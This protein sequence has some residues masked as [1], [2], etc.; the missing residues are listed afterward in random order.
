MSLTL[1]QPAIGST[2]WGGAVNANWQ[3]LLDALN[4]GT[5]TIGPINMENGAGKYLRLPSL[6]TAQRDALT[7]ANGMLI[8]NTDNT[9]FERYENGSWGAF[10]A[11][12]V[13]SVT[14]SS[15]LASSGGTTPNIS[16]S[17]QSG[18]S[19]LASPSNGS[20]GAPS[21]RSLVTADLPDNG[22]TDGKLRDSAST[23][24]I[25][26][27]AGTS[28]DPADIAAANDNEVLRRSSGALGFGTIGTGSIDDNSITNA[29]LRDSA[30]TSVVG[31]SAGTSGDP[32]DIS[33]AS[34]DEVLRRS[35][36]T[37]GFGALGSGSI[38]N[39]AIT[40]AKL[41][42]SSGTSVIGRSAN[43]TGAPA[44]IQASAN[45][46]VL[47]RSSDALS[48]QQVSSGM[49]ADD[50]VTNAKLANMAA[51]TIKGNNTG[52]SADPSDLSG[53]AV[54]AMLSNMVG[55]S[56]SG[57][58][59]GLAPAPAAGDAAAGKFL[60]AD[61]T[62]AVPSG[63]G[64]Q[65]TGYL[66]SNQSI[67]ST[68]LASVT[69]VSASVTSGT[70]YAFRAVIFTD[71]PANSDFKLDFTGPTATFVKYGAFLVLDNGNIFGNDS[72][73][74]TMGADVVLTHANAGDKFIVVEGVISAS[75]TA[76]LQLRA[77]KNAAGTDF[78]IYAGTYL[79]V[80]ELS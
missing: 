69:G 61:A 72:F 55:D 30:A 8:Y 26:R 77:A 54:T 70:V 51:S 44:D 17:N 78:T 59:K 2:N 62:W 24:V 15:P 43:S 42:D 48:F 71:N 11:G 27:S 73:A 64:G 75:S 29:K 20:S 7:A 21:F 57:G 46:R 67:T 74:S 79:M 10:G 40:N 23:S 4:S 56:G 63:G 18:N 19:V 13:T 66:T 32:A 60:K 33:A 52:G 45:D 36:G 76:T 38:S 12:S 34:D 14:A 65:Q 16:I 49:I 68:S 53:S 58:T 3:E 50:A 5:K 37:L 28:G 41:R 9:R 1:T 80:W 22:V 39:S 31:R 47:A 25:G 6:T 35:G